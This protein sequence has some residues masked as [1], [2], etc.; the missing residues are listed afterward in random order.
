M[1]VAL[2]RGDVLTIRWLGVG[3]RRYLVLAVHR[4]PTGVSYDL[5]PDPEDE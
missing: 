1:L 4:T 3:Q 5:L 2:T